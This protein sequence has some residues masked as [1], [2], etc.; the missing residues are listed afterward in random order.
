M[1]M[2]SR[3]R[4]G[5]GAGYHTQTKGTRMVEPMRPDLAEAVQPL[6][7]AAQQVKS[8]TSCT[9]H[10]QCQCSAYELV[11][12]HEQPIGQHLVRNAVWCCRGRPATIPTPQ[13]STYAGSTQI[14][15]T[16]CKRRP[17]WGAIAIG[18]A[19]LAWCRTHMPPAAAFQAQSCGCQLRACIP[20]VCNNEHAACGLSN[21]HKPAGRGRFCARV[22]S[23]LHG[24]LIPV[25]D[26]CQRKTA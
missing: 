6:L 5:S 12:C 4:T 14:T 1:R 11:A 16:S 25:R 15:V 23:E 13:L 17:I 3:R 10:T 19:R 7:S 18:F 22:A 21:P 8:C 24:R 20:C 26:R 2:V 9:T